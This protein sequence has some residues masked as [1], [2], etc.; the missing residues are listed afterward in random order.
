M[1]PRLIAPPV[2]YACDKHL[3]NVVRAIINNSEAERV[4]V[5]RLETGKFAKMCRYGKHIASFI[6]A[7]MEI[8][9]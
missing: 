2:F 5:A 7:D 1:E 3:S 9:R 8:T 4:T 6:V